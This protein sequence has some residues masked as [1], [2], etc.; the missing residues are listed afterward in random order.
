MTEFKPSVNISVVNGTPGEEMVKGYL[1]DL[2]REFDLSPWTWVKDVRIDRYLEALGQCF[3]DDGIPVIRLRSMRPM[4][5]EEEAEHGLAARHRLLCIYL[6]E[7]LH[8]Y[9]ELHSAAT[10][11][12]IQDLRAL[13]PTVPVG[14]EDGARSEHST[15]LHLILCT[16][17]LDSVSSLIGEE[18]YRHLRSEPRF[19]RF[20][21]RTVLSDTQPL[22]EVIQRH[23][24]ALPAQS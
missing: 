19:Y 5:P 22:R 8:Q 24:L 18:H 3:V 21:Y 6:H 2:G 20:I 12:A 23:G 14:G 10:E 16:L 13:Y 4:T 17:E 9:L 7:Q 1:L 11:A 15:Y